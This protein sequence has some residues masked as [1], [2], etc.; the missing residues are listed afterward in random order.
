MIERL[1]ENPFE[2]FV[3][4]VSVKDDGAAIAAIERVIDVAAQIDA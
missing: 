4:A 3:V 2:G 1:A